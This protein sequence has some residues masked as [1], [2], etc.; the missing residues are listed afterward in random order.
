MIRHSDSPSAAKRSDSATA[1]SGYTSEMGSRGFGSD[2][3]ADAQRHP[4]DL[5][6]P[7]ACVTDQNLDAVLN[8]NDLFDFLAACFAAAADLNE[9][10]VPNSQDIFSFV[11]A[12]FAGG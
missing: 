11:G 2:S 7:G 8:C 1:A 4:T 10:G 9:D 3:L 12:F 6:C 5:G